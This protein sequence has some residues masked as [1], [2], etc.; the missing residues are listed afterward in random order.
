M[1]KYIEEFEL[2]C[3]ADLR[4]ALH[5]YILLTTHKHDRCEDTKLDDHRLSQRV[6]PTIKLWEEIPI[7]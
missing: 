6:F 7:T 2:D 5:E 3:R 4:S 1:S